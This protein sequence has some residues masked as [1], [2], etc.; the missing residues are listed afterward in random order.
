[1]SYI[2][3]ILIKS[4]LQTSKSFDTQSLLK[5]QDIDNFEAGSPDDRSLLHWKHSIPSNPKEN[6]RFDFFFTSSI[7]FKLLKDLL[8]L[9]LDSIL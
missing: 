5:S 2:N 9:S 1:M 4:D 7:F 3:H 6:R 8:H